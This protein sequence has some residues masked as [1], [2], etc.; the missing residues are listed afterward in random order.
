MTAND[1]STPP[2]STTRLDSV[3]LLRGLV[4]VLMALD[5]VRF[6]WGA[7]GDVPPISST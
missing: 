5:P 3:D 6:Y 1:A 4:M 2:R 7:P